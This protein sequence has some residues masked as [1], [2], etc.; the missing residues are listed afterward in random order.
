MRSCSASGSGYGALSSCS[1][2]QGEVELSLG[3]LAIKFFNQLSG[4]VVIGLFNAD[5]EDGWAY[6]AWIYVKGETTNSTSAE[7][8]V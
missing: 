4:G 3:A 7:E 8:Q 2:L 1:E 5:D 6:W